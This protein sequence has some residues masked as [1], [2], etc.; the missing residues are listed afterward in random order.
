M[1]RNRPL[2]RTE[3]ILVEC[4]LVEKHVGENRLQGF[5]TPP[6]PPTHTHTH[7]MCRVFTQEIWICVLLQA[8]QLAACTPQMLGW[9]YTTGIPQYYS[10]SSKGAPFPDMQHCGL[11][12]ISFSNGCILV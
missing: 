2:L 9:I 5:R 6:S 7:V 3:C 8:G 11:C 1:L 12:C 10:G 4:V